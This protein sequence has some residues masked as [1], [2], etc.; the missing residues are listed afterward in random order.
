MKLCR[1]TQNQ[2]EIMFEKQQEL[3]YFRF[4]LLVFLLE[5]ILD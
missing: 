3:P 5:K 1:R 4:L 2:K